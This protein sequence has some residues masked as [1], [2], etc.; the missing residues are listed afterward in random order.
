MLKYIEYS[1]TQNSFYVGLEY[2]WRYTGGNLAAINIEENARLAQASMSNTSDIRIISPFTDFNHVTLRTNAKWLDKNFS[3]ELMQSDALLAIRQRKSVK[4]IPFDYLNNYANEYNSRAEFKW[5]SEI[6]ASALNKDRLVFADLAN[7]LYRVSIAGMQVDSVLKIKT[8]KPLDPIS[9]NYSSNESIATYTNLKALHLVDFRDDKDVTLFDS[10][11]FH[12]VCEEL[13]YH[14][15]SLHDNLLYLASSHLLYGIDLRFPKQPLMHWTH[16]LIQ[17]PTMLKRVSYFGDEVICLS[18][19]MQGDMK[20]FNCSKE[21]QPNSWSI[22]HMPFKPR[23]IKNSYQTLREKGLL[24]LSDPI[25]HRVSLST[26]G[27]AMIANEKKSEIQLFTQ[28]SVGD[29]F[30]SFLNSRDELSETVFNNFIQWDDALKDKRSQM[31]ML[32]DWKSSDSAEER[33]KNE[34]LYFTDISNLRGLRNCMRCEKLTAPD[35]RDDSFQMM[36]VRVPRWRQDIEE[37]GEYRDALAQHL[38]AE[39]DLQIEEVTPKLFAEALASSHLNETKKVDM[40]SHWLN[41]IDDDNTCDF[42]EEANEQASI[43]FEQVF[44]QDVLTPRLTQEA[45]ATQR[46]DVSKRMKKVSQ[47]IKGF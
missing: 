12:M 44:S 35:D 16:Q 40:V 27:I 42:K 20:I 7:N 23:N 39:W 33:Q 10:S 25:K 18:S 46:T 41:K 43:V 31:E 21:S 26:T 24:L 19:N 28:N 11:D 13:S 29:V 5:T 2:D 22:S 6:A 15:N 14:K 36:T 8:I 4:F 45:T 34:E 47:R 37:A 32:K 1:E 9:I 3:Y 17:Q 38:L 30:K